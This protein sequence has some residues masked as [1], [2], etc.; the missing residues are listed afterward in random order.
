MAIA[1]SL[2]LGFPISRSCSSF[3]H[4]NQTNNDQNWRKYIRGNALTLHDKYYK[5]YV[6]VNA[7]II[8]IVFIFCAS[9]NR[10]QNTVVN[11]QPVCYIH[12]YNNNKY[13]YAM[14]QAVLGQASRV[15]LLWSTHVHS[16]SKIPSIN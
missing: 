15:V 16:R 4:T 7:I 5:M 8:F 14:M 11:I 12:E 1:D 6:H 3:L 2:R 9:E 10:Q 13:Q